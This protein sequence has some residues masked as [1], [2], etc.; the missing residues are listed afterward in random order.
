LRARIAFTA[1]PG[2]EMWARLKAGLAST[3]GL[4]G[5]L[6]LRRPLK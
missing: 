2:F 5:V 1:S 3:G 6:L 4:L